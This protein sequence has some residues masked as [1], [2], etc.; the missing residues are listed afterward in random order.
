MN[1]IKLKL[2]QGDAPYFFKMFRFM[3]PYKIRY[4]LSQTLYSA[5]GFAMAFIFSIFMGNVMAAIVAGD[6]D[7]LIS[8]GTN[9]GIMIGVFV[10][11]LLVGIYA[12][13]LII[14]KAVL[15]MKRVLFRAFVRTGLEDAAHSGE[16]IAAINTDADTASQVFQGPL[17]SFMMSIITILGSTIVIFERDWRLGLGSLAVGVVSFFMQK[18]FTEPLA[19][20]GKEEL[21]ANAEA[22]KVTSNIFSGAITIRAYNMQPQAFLTFDRE[23]NRLKTL[24][25]RRGFINMGQT[26]FRTVEGWLTLLVVFG[27]GGWLA[28][29][30]R[31]EFHTIAAVFVM[32]SALISAIGQLGANFAGLQ[33]PIAGAKRVFAI[34][35][36]DEA[37]GEVKKTGVTRDANG[38]HLA[39]NDFSF[40]Y[41]D[42]DSD[43]LK[44]INLQINENQM[45]ALVGESGSGKSTLLRAIMGMYERDDIDITVGDLSFSESSLNGWRKNFAYVDQS[46]KLFDMTIKENIAMGVGGRA[47]DEEII[48]AAKLASAHDFIEELEDGYNTPC[49][50]KGDT[51]SGG[52]KQ[53]I[54]IARALIKKAPVLLFDEATSALDKESEKNIMET[55][56]SLRHNHTILFTTHNLN[57][58]ASADKI[59]EME[60]GRI[61][62]VQA[63]HG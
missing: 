7:A 59:V 1:T 6:R 41:I 3:K 55:I 5:Q 34:I 14:E 29:T 49:G 42:A 25:I 19:K 27:F 20:V 63:V 39:V 40:R 51:L 28:A 24:R 2:T 12:N 21:E 47:S 17:M 13:I 56:E 4:G 45:V 50:E 35:E 31:I 61:I 11:M 52:Q 54:A 8:A 62:S 10:V 33:P 44:N 53:R 46:C 43:T 16:G 26:L 23:N 60:N 38:Y 22:L 37:S 48:A 36:R 32:S 9:L 58:A 57:N 18:R 30:G 15:D